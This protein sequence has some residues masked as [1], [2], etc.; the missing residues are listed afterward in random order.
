VLSPGKAYHAGTGDNPKLSF[1]SHGE[2][3]MPT[4]PD[5]L[6]GWIEASGAALAAVLSIISLVVS[7]KTDRKTKTNQ[8]LFW[9]ERQLHELV[10][11]IETVD[12][13]NLSSP[14]DD[15]NKLALIV[16]NKMQ[17]YAAL[18]SVYKYSLPQHA[19]QKL[20]R[21]LVSIQTL[22]GAAIRAANAHSADLNEASLAYV[23]AMANFV[24][25]L[26]NTAANRL[27]QVSE[28]LRKLT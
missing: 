26:K 22:E 19:E 4:S 6:P 25:T 24:I 23:N 15:E 2:H 13:T 27:A 14:G 11:R 8:R 21:D 5:L 16:A 17:E 10:D 18:F 12:K 1:G 9:L 7:I 20:S 28:E 3:V